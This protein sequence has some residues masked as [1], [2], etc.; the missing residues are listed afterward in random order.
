VPVRSSSNIDLLVDPDPDT[1]CRALVSAIERSR[2][3][4]RKR[5]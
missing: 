1:L 4:T 3:A 5:A 2:V